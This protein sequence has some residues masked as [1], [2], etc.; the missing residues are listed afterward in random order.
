MPS[1]YAVIDLGTNTFHLLIVEAKENGHF[2]ELHRE[3][4]FV[5]LAEDGIEQIGDNAI[6]RA[7]R[8]M[9]RYRQILDKYQVENIKAIGTAA[10]RTA[11]NGQD[12]IDTVWKNTKINI[13]LI[14]GKEEARL[15]HLGV[16]QAVEIKNETALIMD[17]GGGSVEFIISDKLGV[18]WA[19]SFPIGVAVLFKAF[20]R[21]DP[22]GQD[23]INHLFSH[24]E[25]TLKPLFSAL[26]NYPASI[27]VGASGT[28]D[29]LENL[30]ADKK[31]NS[32]CAHVSIEAFDVLY[33]QLIFTTLAERKALATIPDDRID[34]IIVALILIEFVVKKANIKE[35]L[36][37]SYAMKEGILHEMMTARVNE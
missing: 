17:I 29:V 36:V 28:F 5:K 3:R 32:T 23:E 31:E 37:S 26:H 24:L 33:G 18:K 14:D 8:A 6:M 15:I 12:F 35:I 10:L 34:M 7:L 4:I 11:T 25:R 21:K 2:L 19:E 1:K 27:L 30:L 9:Q 13:Q 16:N 20:H 22:I